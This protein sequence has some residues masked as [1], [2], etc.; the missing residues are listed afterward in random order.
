MAGLKWSTFPNNQ[1]SNYGTLCHRMLSILDTQKATKK[2]GLNKI[3]E[4]SASTSF[5][6]LT[7]IKE[8]KD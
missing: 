2:M 1:Y 6:N 7:N 8:R 3:K 4:K 5:A